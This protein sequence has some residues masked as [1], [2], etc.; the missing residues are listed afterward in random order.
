M[1][2]PDIGTF[3]IENTKIG[4]DVQFEANHHCNVGTT[5]LLCMPQYILHNVEWKSI[6]KRVMFQS[7]NDKSHDANQNYGGIFSLSPS[8]AAQVLNGEEV[9][10][11]FLP[12][13]FISLVSS[14]FSYLLSLPGD[15][16]ILSNDI[17]FGPQYDNGILC[18]IPLRALKIYSRGLTSKT[19]PQ[20]LV[21][22]FLR[23]GGTAN[24]IGAPDISTN[25]GF[26]QIGED[27]W[28]N[29]QGYSFPVVPG[30]DHSYRISVIGTGVFPSDW[31]VEFS[32]VVI[33]NRWN[34]EYIN[35]N[36]VGRVCGTNGLV[37]SHHD[38]KFIWAGNDFMGTTAWG[39]HGA[40]TPAND[41]MK[42]DCASQ[43]NGKTFICASFVLCVLEYI[44]DLALFRSQNMIGLMLAAHCPELCSESCDEE[45]SYCDCGTQTCQCKAG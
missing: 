34:I 1:A 41:E 39:N 45:N 18:K 24:Q 38:R 33:G 44:S 35:L 28:S 4:D 5:G 8:N 23:E 25:I 37:S 31:V 7:F 12:P 26:H 11:S 15:I 3:I 10:G 40:C 6:S 36:L 20:L 9:D 14:R 42:I 21:E 17:G 22:M 16:C 19:A 2:L 27:Y 30:T 32:D 13:G 29:K 43:N